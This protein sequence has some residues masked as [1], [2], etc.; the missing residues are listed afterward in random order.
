MSPYSRYVKK[1]LVYIIIADPFSC[2]PSSYAKYT[3]LNTCTSCNMRLVSFNK[4]I[5]S[6]RSISL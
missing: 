5:F 3:K 2:Q 6:A 1:G 4:C